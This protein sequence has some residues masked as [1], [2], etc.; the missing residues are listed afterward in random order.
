MC[1][2]TIK[3]R[4]V[5]GSEW[6]YF[7]F[8]VGAKT[9]DKI[10]REAIKPFT[11][12]LLNADIIDQWFFIR[13][14]DPDVHLRV[15]LHFTKKNQVGKIIQTVF[16]HIEKFVDQELI[17][18]VQTDTYQREIERYGIQTMELSEQLFFHEST[19][20]TNILSL[21]KKPVDETPRWIFALKLIDEVLNSF[22][23]TLE[24]KL[25]L[26]QNL[27]DAFGNEFGMNRFL[28]GQID[29]K[30]R[31]EKGLIENALNPI[32]ENN[33]STISNILPLLETYKETI[34]PLSE[35]ILELK[36][37]N[38]L[39]VSLE[40]LMGS[41]IHMTMN[42]I[43]RSNQRVHELVLYDFLFRYYKSTIARQKS[44][45]KSLFVSK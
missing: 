37:N 20:L 25:R 38:R 35:E 44:N 10:L 11:E 5:L 40:N 13:Y 15:R 32:V 23:F 6:I 8:Y 17:W 29:E 4:F 9:A 18:K 22:K 27:K 28:K 16:K 24:D 19:L 34:S 30:Y 14:S 21:L 1:D 2:K 3:R 41:Y 7:K 12:D 36:F 31:K 33:N 45:E 26:L 42:R 39:D 43:F